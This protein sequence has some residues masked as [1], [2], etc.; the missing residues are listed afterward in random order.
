[1]IEGARLWNANPLIFSVDGLVEPAECEA[2]I[3]AATGGLAR[4]PV[5]GGEAEVRTN[6]RALI[7]HR[8]DG[9]LNGLC[10]KIANLLRLPAAHAEP[11]NVLNYQPGEE[12]QPHSD[13]FDLDDPG[14]RTNW[15]WAGS[16]SSPRSSISTWSRRAGPPISPRS[17]S[18]STRP[19]PRHGLRQLLDGERGLCSHAVHAGTPVTAGEKWAATFLVARNARR[20]RRDPRRPRVSFEAPASSDR[21]DIRWVERAGS[22]ADVLSF[23]IP[24]RTG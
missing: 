18:R 13:G 9:W 6:T 7:D 17:A 1:M 11:L 23:P 10:L 12:F 4:A 14:R 19:G 21:L 3:R 22:L 15:R 24:R 20:L 16:G 2:A 5:L 8:K